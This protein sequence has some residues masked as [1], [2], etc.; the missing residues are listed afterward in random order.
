MIHFL[1]QSIFLYLFH[2]AFMSLC[3]L[4]VYDSFSVMSSCPPC[5]YVS[6]S[7]PVSICATLIFPTHIY[8]PHMSCMSPQFIFQLRLDY[9]CH[10]PPAH[11]L[12]LPPHSISSLWKVKLFDSRTSAF[13]LHTQPETI[14]MAPSDSLT[15]LRPVGSAYTC[16]YSKYL[17]HNRR[18]AQCTS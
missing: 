13:R 16:I 18:L 7:I 8:K 14:L 15:S 4:S 11:D 9:Y 10:F 17:D 12:S 1:I 6:T 5:P 2:F 3:D